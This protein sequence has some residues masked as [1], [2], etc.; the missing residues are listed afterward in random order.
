MVDD[1]RVMSG[2]CLS[3]GYIPSKAV[4]ETFHNYVKVRQLT[5]FRLDYRDIV[6]RKNDVQKLR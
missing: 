2:Y 3:E 1:R 6:K 5:D 4:I